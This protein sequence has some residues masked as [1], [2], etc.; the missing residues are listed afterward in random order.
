M[1]EGGSSSVLLHIFHKLS[2]IKGPGTRV[3]CM[4]CTSEF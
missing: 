3:I 4:L 1:L 2:G